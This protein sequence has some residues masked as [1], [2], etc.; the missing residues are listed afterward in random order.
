MIRG[1]EMMTEVYAISPN[2]LIEAKILHKRLSHI[3]FKGLKI[4]YKQGIL[5]QGIKDRLSCCE[6]CVMVKALRHILPKGIL[7]Y[8]HS[9]LWGQPLHQA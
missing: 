6:H 8:T 2:D 5:P 9:N 4:L 1:I 7:D 3:S